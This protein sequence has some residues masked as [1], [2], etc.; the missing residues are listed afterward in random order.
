VK[1]PFAEKLYLTVV[2]AV[3]ANGMPGHLLGENFATPLIGIAPRRIGRYRM[4]P[5]EQL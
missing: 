4:A 1:S 3:N 5:P 2:T